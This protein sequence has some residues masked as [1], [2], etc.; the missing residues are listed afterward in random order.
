M[1]MVILKIYEK[2]EGENYRTAARN[3]TQ[4]CHL[5]TLLTL[6]VVCVPMNGIRVQTLST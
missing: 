4:G 1:V 6:M 5:E 2:R 3:Q